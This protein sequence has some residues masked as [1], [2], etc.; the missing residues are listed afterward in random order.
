MKRFPPVVILL[1]LLPL[2][3]AGHK[4]AAPEHQSL[5]QRLDQKNGYKQ[6]GHGNWVPQN[7]KRSQLEAKGESP[8]FKGQYAGKGYQTGSYDKKSWWGNKNYGTQ[9]YANHADGSRFQKDSRYSR[10][11][12]PESATSAKLSGA[13]QTGTY[14]TGAARE[15]GRQGVTKT[16]NDMT[17]SRRHGYEP[18]EVIDWREQRNLSVDQSKSLLGH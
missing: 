16:T 17:E 2:S 9:A 1:A 12:A 11:G 5:S 10:Q 13:Y 6:D 7:D 15:A 18:P 14:A 3:C 4:T 8:Y